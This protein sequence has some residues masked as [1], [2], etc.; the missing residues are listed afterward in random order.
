M[1]VCAL[2]LHAIKSGFSRHSPDN[3]KPCTDGDGLKGLIAVRIY[4]AKESFLSYNDCLSSYP[5]FVGLWYQ[6]SFGDL[7]VFRWYHKLALSCP[8]PIS[9]ENEKK[10]NEMPREQILTDHELLVIGERECICVLSC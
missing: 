2:F 5:L 1:L 7:N 10:R 8:G 6:L 4:M 9:T 3:V